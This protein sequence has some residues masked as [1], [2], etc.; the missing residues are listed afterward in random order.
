[1]GD[2]RTSGD[3]DLLGASSST[4]PPAA[5]RDPVFDKR[6][7][8]QSI[9]ERFGQQV[10][11]YEEKIAVKD[12]T[13]ALTYRDLNEA[14]NRVAGI[15]LRHQQEEGKPV[16][17]LFAHEVS[18]V[19]AILGTLK[20][21]KAYVP[22]D[23]LYPA[24]RT[25]Y[26]LDDSQSRLIL[27]NKKNLPLA[28]DLAQSPHQVIDIDQIDGNIP[29]DDIHLTIAPGSLAYI[30]YSSGSTGQPKGITHNHRNVHHWVWDHTHL[31]GLRDN[32]RLA[33]SLSY[34]FS[35]SVSEIF[36]ALLN[37]ATLCLY[38]LR[39]NGLGELA[40]WLV[41]EEITVYK[42]SIPVFR[43][44][45][46]ALQGEDFLFPKLR[47]I[48]LGGDTLYKRDVDSFRK[49]L[50]SDC[51]LAYR[52]ASTEAKHLTQFIIDSETEITDSKIPVGYP[53]EDTDVLILD[54]A[55]RPVDGGEVGEIVVRSRY[56]SPGYWRR[57]DLNNSFFVDDPGGGPERTYFT[58]DLGRVL[59]GGC[60]EHRGRKDAMVK[61]RGY[62]VEVAEIASALHTVDSVED[63]AVVARDGLSGEKELVAYVVASGPRTPTA[64]ELRRSLAGS[65]PDHMI[66]SAFVFLESLPMTATGK[67]DLQALLSRDTVHMGSDAPYQAPRT[68]VEEI[69]S[70][71]WKDVLGRGFIGMYDSFVDLGGNSLLA[72]QVNSRVF[73]S[74]QLELPTASL[75]KTATIA[76]LAVLVTQQ[77]AKRAT[78]GEIDQM[79][80][81]L[82]GL[83]DEEFGRRPKA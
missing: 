74:F 13:A 70:E 32:D 69:L 46:R 31:F 83:S 40:S 58:G 21:G 76:E 43:F 4:S 71:I 17:L 55:G 78:Q 9:P 82:E 45:K 41:R 5:H 80:E 64:A 67:I 26:V 20:A 11:R 60:L 47:L 29:C 34:S 57:P 6:D 33:L 2:S 12:D 25:K 59:P 48:L 35:A 72:F 56:I 16:A 10:Q 73:E 3:G 52:L 51:I 66:P 28:R 63:A 53:A 27:T 81:D 7:I 50:H 19:T 38:D 14:S 49:H 23:P 36:G 39:K 1:V 37:G 68:P 8:E 44:L 62:R 15:I 42:P 30:L 65:L 54:E 22:L 77:L 75:F 61:I 18:A 79:L 24:A